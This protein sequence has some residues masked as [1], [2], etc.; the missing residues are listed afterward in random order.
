[1][2]LASRHLAVRL[3]IPVALAGVLGV[4]ALFGGAHAARADDPGYLAAIKQARAICQAAAEGDRV[5]AAEAVIAVRHGTGESQSEAIGDLEADPPRFRLAAQR[6]QAVESALER[7]ASPADPARAGA[8]LR[9]ILA[10]SRYQANGPSLLDRIQ[11]WLLEQLSR[12][13]LFL[14]GGSG[15]IGRLIELAVAGAVGVGLAVFLARSLWSRRGRGTATAAAR[16]RPRHAVDWFAEADRLAAAGDFPA[17]LRAL[18]SGVA[19]ALGGEGA[20][21][22]SPLTV[23]ELFVDAALSDPLRPLLVPF[24]A[25]AYGHRQPDAAVYARAAE[26]AAPFRGAA[27][28]APGAPRPGTAQPR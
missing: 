16:S 19:T 3:G 7:P 5:A 20:W 22:T 11:A 9:S 10:E 6:L 1:M 15:N 21:E 24:E 28:A 27:P 25:S 8:E 4:L 12:L 26:V 14:A 13:L 18:T 23:R 17:A 2:A